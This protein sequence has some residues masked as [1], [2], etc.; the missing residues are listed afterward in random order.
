MRIE[1]FYFDL[2]GCFRQIRLRLCSPDALCY[3]L[4]KVACVLFN[5]DKES[6]Y[7]SVPDLSVD[8]NSWL[9]VKFPIRR[10]VL[11]WLILFKLRYLELSFYTGKALLHSGLKLLLQVSLMNIP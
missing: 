4:L 9:S 11:I 1:V 10:C 5:S 2:D 6:F 8:G 7:R 3:E